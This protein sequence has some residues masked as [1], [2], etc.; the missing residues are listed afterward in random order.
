MGLI[1]PDA[2]N[3]FFAEV[4]QAIERA[5]APHGLRS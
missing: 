2:A 3:P 4:A 1:V 5:A